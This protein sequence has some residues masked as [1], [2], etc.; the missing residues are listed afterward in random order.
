[1]LKAALSIPVLLGMSLLFS[2]DGPQR[3]TKA[4]KDT[5]QVN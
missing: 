4:P 2:Q 5:M 3:S 1:M